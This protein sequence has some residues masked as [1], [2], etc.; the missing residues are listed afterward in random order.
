MPD[1]NLESRAQRLSEYLESIAG[2]IPVE[3]FVEVDQDDTALEGVSKRSLKKAADAAIRSSRGGRLSADDLF[4]AEAIVHRTKRPSHRIENGKFDPFPGEFRYLSKNRSV[5]KRISDTFEAIGRVDIPER[6]TYGGTGFV[7]GNNLVMTNRHVAEIFTQGVGRVNV[8]I[9]LGET[10]IDFRDEPSDVADGFTLTDCVMVH[11]YWDMALFRADL[12]DVQLLSLA[13]T[14][15]ADLLKAKQDVVLVGYPARDPRNGVDAQR[16]IFGSDFEVKRIAPGRIAERKRAIGSK[17]LRSSVDALAHDSSSLG[18][19]SGSPVISVD[20]AQV[21]GLHFAGRYL[22]ENYGVPC[23]EL[24]RDP[25]VVDA[26][27][28]FDA[29][30]GLPS[31]SSALDR[32]WREADNESTQLPKR[33]T[34]FDMQDQS[35]TSSKTMSN[36]QKNQRT[37]S[38]LNVGGEVTIEIPLRIS[39]SLGAPNSGLS[40]N[41]CSGDKPC[42]GSDIAGAEVE[43]IGQGYDE[44]FLSETVLTPE[45]VAEIA[46]DVFEV[47]GSHLIPYT[48]FSV[49]QSKSRTLPRFV[50]WNI[51][52][53]KLISVDRGNNF[54]RDPRVPNEFQADNALYR[55][56]PYD[57]GHV[58]RRA[59][60]NWGPRRE[61]ERANSDSFFYTN[62]TPQHQSFNQSSRHGLW[63]ELE[64]AVF[65]DIKVEDLKV[66]VMG[67]PIF[68]EDD[69]EH[70]GVKIPRDFWKLLAFRDTADGEF[71][72]AAYVLSQKEFVPTEVLELDVF[73]LYQT[74]LSKLGQETQLNFDGLSD[75]D[76]FTSD[77]EAVSGSGVREVIGREDLLFKE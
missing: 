52:G 21:V 5:R 23:H 35:N 61:A 25:R 64:N 71:K 14:P 19:N 60:L 33:P 42:T 72:V 45:L 56:N 17:W 32:F 51:D 68:R 77:T 73:R 30:D 10:E 31:P 41:V 70:R 57:R 46:D 34:I 11:P 50:A 26:G 1:N 20:S 29:G 63:G 2:D 44:G 67:G 16:E 12:P 49:C 53:G 75:F 66:S 7:V 6:S 15:Y 24:A 39:V 48:H 47:D 27:V 76:T 55:R 3:E 69:P 13:V 65:K 40:Y 9:R 18:G 74:S 38:S 28:N 58:A 37:D 22:V 36:D 62:I 8:R 59:D 4:H 43:S 54:R